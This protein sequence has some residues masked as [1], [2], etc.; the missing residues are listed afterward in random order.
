M[1]G[2]RRPDHVRKLVQ[3]AADESLDA[4]AAE[5]TE[6]VGGAWQDAGEFRAYGE[7]GETA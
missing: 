3:T 7:S 2:T 6:A 4:S 5:L 1:F